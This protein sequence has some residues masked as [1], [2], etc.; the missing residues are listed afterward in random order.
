VT[1]RLEIVR[2]SY[3][4]FNR[5]DF[6]AAVGHAHPEIEYQPVDGREPIRGV[7]AYRQWMEPDAF[8]AMA[9]TLVDV[10]SCGERVL[11]RQL[12]KARG[13]GSG[14][15]MEMILFTV[16]T[17]DGDDRVV[18]VQAFLPHQETEARQAAGLVE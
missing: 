10:E 4:A 14:I 9:V 7:S 2:R 3:E 11:V 15:E 8:E 6:D 12:A 13:A 17:F 1:D 5:Q 16:F 18:R